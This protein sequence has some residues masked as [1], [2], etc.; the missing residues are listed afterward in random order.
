[1]G[2]TT[3]SEAQAEG[4]AQCHLASRPFCL[5]WLYADHFTVNPQRHALLSKDKSVAVHLKAVTEGDFNLM[6]GHAS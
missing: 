6:V 2:R 1:M 4:H 3:G 5:V